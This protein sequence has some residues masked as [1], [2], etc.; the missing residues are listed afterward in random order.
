MKQG[1]AMFAVVL[2]LTWP[3]AGQTDD[4]VLTE[5]VVNATVDDV[6]K[7]WTTK[8]GIE[9]WMTAKADI[10]LKVG[11]LLRTSYNAASTLDDDASIHHVILAFDPGRMLAFRT[12][13]PPR[14]FPWPSAIAQTWTVVYLEPVAPARTKVTIR[15]LGYRDDD[16]L[17]QMKPFFEKGNRVTLDALKKKF[18][19]S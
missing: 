9:S 7:A 13:K 6:W 2:M 10:D 17:R 15:M 1:L 19:G 4:V 12:V 11:A 3:L 5:D 14:T 8:A 16:E 18:G